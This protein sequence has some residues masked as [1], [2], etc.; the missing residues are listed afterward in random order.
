MSEEQ[1]GTDMAHSISESILFVSSNE[2]FVPGDN[3]Y[4]GINHQ[5]LGDMRDDKTLNIEIDGVGGFSFT[6]KDHPN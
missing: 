1:L 2:S 5:S 4:V 6:V 3:L